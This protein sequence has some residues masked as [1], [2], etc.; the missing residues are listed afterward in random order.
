MTPIT[1]R[2]SKEELREPLPP[3]CIITGEDTEETVVQKFSF[4]PGW[5]YVLPASADAEVRDDYYRKQQRNR[6]S[7]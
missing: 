1:I 4:T 2:L 7:E 5:V 3:I 6:D